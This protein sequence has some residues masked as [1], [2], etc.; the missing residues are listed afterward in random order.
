MACSSQNKKQNKKK[1]T[2]Y[3]IKVMIVEQQKKERN[4]P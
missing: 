4:E 2:I 3:Q 1:Q